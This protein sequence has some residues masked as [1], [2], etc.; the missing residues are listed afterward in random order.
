MGIWQNLFGMCSRQPPDPPPAPTPPPPP[1]SP[2][3]TPEPAALPGSP[4]VQLVEKSPTSPV[5][6]NVL[7]VGN[8][9][10]RISPKR[11]KL[12]QPATVP[13]PGEQRI[14]S[15]FSRVTPGEAAAQ[16]A[17]LAAK[18]AIEAEQRKAAVAAAAAAVES[19][20]RELIQGRT[21]Q[22]RRLKA[23]SRTGPRTAKQHVPLL[24]LVATLA[25][26]PGDGA[27]GTVVR[28][29]RNMTRGNYGPVD[30]AGRVIPGGWSS[31]YRD[32]AY[33][34]HVSVHGRQWWT[35]GKG[36]TGASQTWSAIQA[37]YWQH[38]SNLSLS[39][40]QNWV[41]AWRAAEQRKELGRAG[42]RQ[43]AAA[44]DA[45]ATAAGAENGDN[46]PAVA[47]VVDVAEDAAVPRRGRPRML[48]DHVYAALQQ[49]IRDKVN[50]NTGVS[51]AR[52]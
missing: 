9:R 28:A 7:R 41:K 13:R 39:T 8:K 37:Q 16:A 49:L 2:P 19:A 52:P 31:F 3:A 43:V 36:S 33:R 51:L 6:V 27:D 34:V 26:V 24:A 14:S 20:K 45:A 47:V 30:E 35:R 11:I 38:F 18:E 29:I 10:I 4:E 23:A 40:V 1:P 48:P 22:R 32:L 44:I 17:A 42:A 46:V 50:S 12:L 25:Q 21:D 15:F 5:L